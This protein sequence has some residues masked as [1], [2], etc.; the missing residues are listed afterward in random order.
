M[1]GALDVLVE[2]L[3]GEAPFLVVLQRVAVLDDARI[4]EDLEARLV[5]RH[6]DDDDALEHAHLIGGEADARSRVHGFRHVGG[7]LLELLVEFRHGFGAARK[8]DVRILDDRQNGHEKPPT[9]LP[10]RGD[11]CLSVSE[12][13]K[14]SD[15]ASRRAEP[16]IIGRSAAR[17]SPTGGFRAC[18]GKR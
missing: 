15:G 17:N 11:S 13:T 2:P 3:E 4:D 8:S 18:R 5:F 12:R 7:E 6:V 9:R 1:I 16:M 10:S 14:L